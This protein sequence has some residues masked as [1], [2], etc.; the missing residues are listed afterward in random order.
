MQKRKAWTETESGRVFVPPQWPWGLRN[1]STG[2]RRG[3]PAALRIPLSPIPAKDWLREEGKPGPWFALWSGESPFLLKPHQASVTEGE[4][5]DKSQRSF[6]FSHSSSKTMTSMS[7]SK[8]KVRN[9]L[10]AE[11]RN[12]KLISQRQPQPISVIIPHCFRG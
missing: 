1:R 9:Q 12:I 2:L 3:P 8:G 4:G 11:H 7:P 6:Q 10:S 5:I